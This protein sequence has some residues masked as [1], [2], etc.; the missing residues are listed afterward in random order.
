M[1]ELKSCPFCGGKAEI[2]EVEAENDGEKF[3]GFVVGCETCG[4]STP[5]SENEAE[6]TALWN[7][8]VT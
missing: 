8:R 2:Y 4:I 1:S 7:K 6:I 3:S 5:A